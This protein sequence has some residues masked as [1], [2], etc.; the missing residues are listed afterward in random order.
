MV[1]WSVGWMGAG[2]EGLDGESLYELVG[3]Y[4]VAGRHS[5]ESST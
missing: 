3:E 2:V 1:G 5:L 4:L